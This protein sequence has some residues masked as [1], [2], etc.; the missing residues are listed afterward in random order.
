VQLEVLRANLDD[1]ALTLKAQ[2]FVS[3]AR[4]PTAARMK[5]SSEGL[6]AAAA[7]ASCSRSLRA[8]A[9]LLMTASL[10]LDGFKTCSVRCL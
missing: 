5:S 8:S 7:M 1:Q 3:C 2:R 9:A 4:M 10:S 6:L